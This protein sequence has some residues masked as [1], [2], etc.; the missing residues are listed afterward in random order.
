MLMPRDSSHNAVRS[1]LSGK[2]SR[3]S[4]RAVP[5]SDQSR[6]HPP[7]VFVLHALAFAPGAL[8]TEIVAQGLSLAYHPDLRVVLHTWGSMAP[9][10]EAL[11]RGRM[12]RVGSRVH[13]CGT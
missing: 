2:G 3:Q 13:A 10:W 6:A 4:S 12:S 7:F 8:A 9:P 11:P 5:T 1:I